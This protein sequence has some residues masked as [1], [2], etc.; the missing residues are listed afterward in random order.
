MATGQQRPQQPPQPATHQ[1]PAANGAPTQ[2]VQL[3]ARAGEELN[4][5]PFSDPSRFNLLS[6]VQVVKPLSPFHMVAVQAVRLSADPNDGDVY[7]DGANLRPTKVALMKLASG[8][9]I[10]WYP[11]ECKMLYRDD[12]RVA[13]QAVGVLV[14]PDGV[15][16]PI[17]GTKEV[18]L[19]VLEDE[20]RLQQEEK[21]EK[22]E[23]T[24]WEELPSGKSRPIKRDWASPEEYEKAVER[25]VRRELINKRKNMVALAETG[26]YLRATRAALGL[27]SNW[28]RQEI[29]RPF[30]M[31][32]T[33]VDP[34]ADREMLREMVRD[35]ARWSVQA[36]TPVASRAPTVA[37]LQAPTFDLS[38]VP[39]G[40]DDDGFGAEAAETYEGE[41]PPE[42]EV[43][44]HANRLP[45]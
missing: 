9:G 17:K 26:A 16:R 22:G 21:L 20:I 2:A 42:E 8:A 13:F 1:A 25:A 15:P 5:K 18:D 31:V 41:V 35:T 14:G 12:K 34:E 3:Y 11:P 30:V 7:K 37:L 40:P 29:E 4:L 6:A 38:T 24:G 43:A 33:Y 45:L 10:Q 27:K 19:G 36:P 28:T 44:G 39:E 32:R 23:V